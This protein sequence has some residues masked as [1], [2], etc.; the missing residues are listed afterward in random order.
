MA[1]KSGKDNYCVYVHINKINGKMY[2][3]QSCNLHE[4]W[5]CQGK[6]YFNSIKF[7]HAIKK[8]GWDNFIHAVIKDNMFVDEADA[9]EKELI[10]TFDTINNG[11]NLKEG[12]ARGELSP[13][14][15]KKMGDGVH[16]AF[17]E[18]PEIIEKIRIA[19][20]GLKAS[21]ESKRKMSLNGARTILINI[22]GEIGSFR[23]WAKRIGTT[24]A[25]LVY[26]KK[27]EG[28]ESVIT[29]IREMLKQ[30]AA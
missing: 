10:E 26:R 14:S 6:N 13:E 24:H 11:Y 30:Q 28:I 22:D 17:T 19:R 12:G 15:L 21:E 23:Y 29:Y 7:F 3:G 20:I 2:V 5:R 25:P 16:R 8:Y 4:R 18:Y 27:K 1:R 9:V